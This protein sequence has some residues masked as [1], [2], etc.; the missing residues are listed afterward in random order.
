MSKRK[1]QVMRDGEAVSPEF[2]TFNEAFGWLLWHQPHSVHK[3]TTYE[4]YEIKGKDEEH[5][6]EPG[7][8]TPIR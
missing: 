6:D 4:G 3:A 7:N 8:I 1:Y 2:E 5:G